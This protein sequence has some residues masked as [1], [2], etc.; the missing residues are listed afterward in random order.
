MTLDNIGPQFEGWDILRYRV[1]N[2]SVDRPLF[3]AVIVLRKG[4]HRRQLVAEGS[5]PTAALE[6]VQRQLT[7]N[8][9]VDGDLDTTPR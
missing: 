8:A 7:G 5:T 6:N 3:R 4:D 1:R 9:I 2:V